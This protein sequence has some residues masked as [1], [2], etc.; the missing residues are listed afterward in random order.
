MGAGSRVRA[1]T[2]RLGPDGLRA[3]ARVLRRFGLRVE[4]DAAHPA[5][6]PRPGKHAGIVR[7]VRLGLAP[8]L[9]PELVAVEGVS[10]AADLW[11]GAYVRPDLC[12]CPVRFLTSDES[13][14]HPQA[15]DIAVEVV[16][17]GASAEDVGMAADRYAAAGVRA[18]LVIDPHAESGSWTLHSEP[19]AGHYWLDRTGRYGDPVPLTAAGVP[20]AGLHSDRLPTVGLPRYAAV[21]PPTQTR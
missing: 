2:V 5:P 18:L 17:P 20:T 11:P 13:L 1:R 7:A 4:I 16:L 14:L 6:R 3:A 15:V 21:P 19:V 9:P 12:V 8:R 10:V